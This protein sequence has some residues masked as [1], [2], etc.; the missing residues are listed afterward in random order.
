MKRFNQLFLA[1]ATLLLLIVANSS[2]VAQVINDGPIQLQ[3]R[4]REVRTYF[5]ASDQLL[6]LTD[7]DE[8][9][10][11]VWA[12]ANTDVLNQGWLGGTCLQSDFNPSS[13][14]TNSADF[15]TLLLNTVY[16]GPGVPAR[17]NKNGANQHHSTHATLLPDD[18]SVGALP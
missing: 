1:F 5:D 3:V 7:P 10:Y 18:R 6:G 8:L 11:Y 9:T 16:P 13:T 4:L 15:N 17:R 12:R 2:V 14:G